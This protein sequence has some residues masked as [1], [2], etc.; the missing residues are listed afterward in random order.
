[1]DVRGVAPKD[2]V[3]QALIL[4]CS[5]IAGAVDGDAPSVLVPYVSFEDQPGFVAEGTPIPESDPEDTQVQIFTG[6][7]AILVP[8]SRE[9]MGQPDASALL[10]SAAREAVI[11]KANRAFLTQAA[12]VAPAATPPAG[13]LTGVTE[14]ADDIETAGSLDPVVDAIAKIEA[15]GGQASNILVHPNGWAQLSKMKLAADSAQT[16]LGAG[17]A[18]STA[19]ARALLNVPVLVDKDVPEDQLVVLD[20]RA[21]LSVSGPVLLAQSSEWLFNYDSMALRITWRFGAKVAKP[22]RLVVVPL[23]AGV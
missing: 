23:T 5:T 19:P 12:P 17:S 10:S 16:L 2:I 3:S 15:D 18:P 7:V 22:D 21:I 9:Q 6:K 4:Q 1:M 8:V 20:K 13:I 14:E 11:R